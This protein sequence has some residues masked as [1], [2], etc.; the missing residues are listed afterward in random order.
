M[1]WS[2][3][4]AEVSYHISQSRKNYEHLENH[5][6]H[7]HYLKDGKIGFLIFFFKPK[8]L[9]LNNGLKHFLEADFSYFATFSFERWH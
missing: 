5:L 1:C 8:T 2:L 6:V 9:G 3:G 7:P 4:Y